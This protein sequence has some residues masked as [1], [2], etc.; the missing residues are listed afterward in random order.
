[1]K[2]SGI[3]SSSQC[4]LMTKS[5]TAHGS[6]LWLYRRCQ[7]QAGT[8]KRQAKG[9]TAVPVSLPTTLI[10]MENC[11]SIRFWWRL[12]WLGSWVSWSLLQ[13]TWDEKW[14]AHRNGRESTAGRVDNNRGGRITNICG[15]LSFSC[16]PQNLGER[17]K[18]RWKW[19]TLLCKKKKKW[20][21]KMEKDYDSK[22]I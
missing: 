2:T 21:L 16:D 11:V 18:S 1:M 20:I 3:L 15:P 19:S 13:L 10:L 7:K 12:L 6:I 4:L 5:T 14:R 22:L 17:K 8:W 9:I